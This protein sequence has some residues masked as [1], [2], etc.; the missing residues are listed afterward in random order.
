MQ[1]WFHRRMWGTTAEQLCGARLYILWKCLTAENKTAFTNY[2]AMWDVLHGRGNRK[3]RLLQLVMWLR[4]LRAKM[5]S[6]VTAAGT[7]GGRR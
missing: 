6:V 2:R 4:K 7:A 3:S 5:H 1:N